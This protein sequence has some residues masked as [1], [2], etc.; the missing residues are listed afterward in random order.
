M[1]NVIIRDGKIYSE[2]F[3]KVDVFEVVDKIPAGFFVWNIGENMGHDEYN[4]SLPGFAA[5]GQRLFRDQHTYIKSYQAQPGGST[6]VKKGCRL[7]S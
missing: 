7:R 5:G 2:S 3:G 4:T 1:K 6:A